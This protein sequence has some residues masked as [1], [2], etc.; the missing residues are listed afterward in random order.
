[1]FRVWT[2]RRIEL[3]LHGGDSRRV[4][5]NC[6][7]SPQISGMTSNRTFASEPP[8]R[9]LGNRVV[10]EWPTTQQLVPPTPELLGRVL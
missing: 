4:T 2:Q 10:E 5:T 3:L 9:L 6:S 7:T 1:M 8:R